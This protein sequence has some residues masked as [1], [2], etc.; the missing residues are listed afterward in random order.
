MFSYFYVRTQCGTTCRC[1][2]ALCE[3]RTW[4]GR[5]GRWTRWSTTDVDPRGA[6]QRGKTMHH[7]PCSFCAGWPTY[8]LS[9]Y[10]SIY[11]HLQTRIYIFSPVPE[12]TTYH[13]RPIFDWWGDISPIIISIS[14]LSALILTVCRPV[15]VPSIYIDWYCFCDGHLKLKWIHRRNCPLTINLLTLYIRFCTR[16]TTWLHDT[17]THRV[18]H[19]P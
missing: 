12:T 8:T 9:L 7:R 4:R 1:T 13:H 2:S 16:K 11:L 18:P 3:W 17:H 15:S 6:A 14:I 19:T 10:I 5:C